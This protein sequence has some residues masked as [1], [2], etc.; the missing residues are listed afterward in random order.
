MRTRIFGSSWLAVVLVVAAGLAG[1]A[2]DLGPIDRTQHNIVKKDDILGQ[3]FY[4]RLTVLKAP[5]SSAYSIIGDQGRLERGVF[6]IRE[7]HLVFLRTY[8]WI[9]GSEQIAARPDTDTVLKDEDGNPV[10]RLV[11]VDG[12]NRHIGP[13]HC[14]DPIEAV[15]YVYRGAPIETFPIS[16]HFDIVREYNPSTGEKTNVTSENSAD[17]MWYERDYMRV[18]WSPGALQNFS[19]LMLMG[20]RTEY[21]DLFNPTVAQ[22]DMFNYESDPTRV[23]GFSVYKGEADEPRYQPRMVFTED[24]E[25]EQRLH[26][27]DFVS[28]WVVQAPT[29]YYEFWDED[30]PLCWFFPWASGGVFECTTEELTVRASFLA[31][32]PDNGFV[33]HDYDDNK[34]EKFGF[35]RA[36]RQEFDREFGSTYG[37]VI[38]KAF[39]HPIWQTGREADGTI[40]PEEERE[41]KPIVYYLSERYPRELVDEAIELSRQWSEPFEDVI[42]YY[43]GESPRMF[44]VCENNNDD[45]RAAFAAGA[46]FM[47]PADASAGTHRMAVAY[48]GIEEMPGYNPLCL[49]MEEVKYNGDLRYHQLHAVVE[50]QMGGLLG[51]G[52]PSADPLTGEI[53]NANA[54]NYTGLL[55]QY[56]NRIM[57]AIEQMAG[58]MSLQDYMSGRHIAK[59]MRELRVPVDTDDPPRRTTME[60]VGM[61]SIIDDDVRNSLQT[62]GIELSDTNWARARMGILS[63]DPTMERSLIDQNIR[64]LFRDPA[65]AIGGPLQDNMASKM[66]LKNWANHAGFKRQQD[67]RLEAS[68][69]GIDLAGFAD[70]GIADVV[71]DFRTRFDTQVCEAFADRPDLIFDYNEFSEVMPDWRRDVNRSD[72]QCSEPGARDADGYECASAFINGRQGSYWVRECPERGVTNARGWTCQYVDQGEFAGDYWVNTCTTEKLLDQIRARIREDEFTNPYAH[73]PPHALWT[74][75]RVPEVAHTQLEIRAM[76]SE[77]RAEFV[78]ELYEALFLAVAIHE[79]GHNLG[80]RHNFTGSTDALNYPKEFWYRKAGVTSEQAA[81]G[82]SVFEDGVYVASSSHPDFEWGRETREQSLLGLRGL[83]SASVMDYGGKF[84]SEFLGVGHYDRAA[85]KFGYGK[86]VE[87]FEE[88]PDLDPYMVY[89]ESPTYDY[90]STRPLRYSKGDT[91]EDIFRRVHYTQLPN[92]FGSSNDAIEAMYAR[93]DV[94]YDEVAAGE[95]TVPYRFCEYDRVGSDP[96]CWPRSTGADP[97]EIVVNALDDHETFDWFFRGYYHGSVLFWPDDYYYS[98]RSTFY[99]AKLQYQWWALNLAHYNHNDWWQN[100]PGRG[101]GPNGEDLPWDEDPSGGLAGKLAAY[102]SYGALAAAFGRPVPGY[103]GYNRRTGH[104]EHVMDYNPDNLTNVF[105]LFED[106]GARPMYAG[107]SNEGYG[108]YPVRAGSIYE[109]LAAFEVLTDP[110]SYFKGVDMSSDV[111]RYRLSFYTLFPDETLNLLGGVLTGQTEGYGLCIRVNDSGNMTSMNRRHYLA[112][113]DCE[114]GEIPLTPEPSDYIFPTTKYRLPMLAAYYGMSLMITDYDRRFMDVTRVFLAGHGTELE[115]AEGTEVA[116]FECPFSGKIYVAAK[117]GMNNEFDPAYYLVTE[118]ARELDRY[119]DEDTGEIRWDALRNDYERSRLEFLT[120]KLE[121]IRSMH[122]LYETTERGAAA[123]SGGG[124]Y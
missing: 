89:L 77:L 17:R 107:W 51:F 29:I 70:P 19:R 37:A 45:A 49:D 38:R 53:I 18:D 64:L 2:A 40:I 15:V 26:Y 93:R 105:R 76:L 95:R 4:Y 96:W 90:P 13:E 120:G 119:R 117:T 16:S 124:S 65:L 112:G 8:E 67:F 73:W 24:A 87:V 108:I 44:I 81:R 111:R 91:M 39:L 30:I 69:R 52:P 46:S 80:L 9:E 74:D 59:E 82:A 75:S 28:H 99:L 100:G 58:V 84:N 92:T 33:S 109:R 101:A 63:Q 61:G 72:G 20:L 118:A 25:T 116:N 11:C 1:C 103:Y 102:E 55:R 36:E 56:A 85:I 14:D 7:D 86:L 21:A 47:D 22:D 3:E 32:D 35:Y 57:D 114:P 106:D 83:Q 12:A 62:H 113:L 54:Y 79:V 48:H 42:S 60:A 5:Y 94:R 43:K 88:A 68:N 66:S 122:T 34:L 97:F 104:F 71:E 27:M 23:A 6:E 115:F 10:T 78:S 31:V 110:T 41:P 50:P 123:A 121:L 98:V